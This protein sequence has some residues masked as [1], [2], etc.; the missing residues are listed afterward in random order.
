MDPDDRARH[1]ALVGGEAQKEDPTGEPLSPLAL[2][3]PG[4]RVLSC[5]QSA[6][7]QHPHPAP[8][9]IVDDERDA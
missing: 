2:P 8:R 4:L 9:H 1:N 3:V 7:S 5:G 6:A